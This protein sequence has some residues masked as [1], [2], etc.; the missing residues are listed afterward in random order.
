MIRVTT[1]RGAASGVAGYLGKANEV[2]RY[3]GGSEKVPEGL[4]AGQY[5]GGYS[6]GLH[7]KTVGA[8]FR[9]VLGGRDLNG[10]PLYTNGHEGR[11]LGFDMTF[12]PDKSFSI[13]WARS[14]KVDRQKIEFVLEQSVK[15][16]LEYVEKEVLKDCVRRGK[17]GLRRESAKEFTWAL[18][19]HGTSREQDPQ[20]HVHSVLCNLVQRQDGSY[21][22]IAEKSLYERQAEIRTY[23]DL[24]L[25]EKVQLQLGLKTER[26]K[27]GFRIEGI[28][29][30]TVEYFSKRR[31]QILLESNKAGVSTQDDGKTLALKTRARKSKSNEK[32]L[33]LAWQKEMDGH[34]FTEARMKQMVVK[35]ELETNKW[36]LESFRM[37]RKKENSLSPFEVKDLISSIENRITSE[38]IGVSESK[39]RSLC[40]AEAV[41]KIKTSELQDLMHR[42]LQ[43]SSLVVKEDSGKKV[44]TTQKAL[45]LL[46]KNREKA[47]LLLN[48]ENHKVDVSKVNAVLHK[49][50]NLGMSEEQLKAVQHVCMGGDLRLFVGAAGTGKSFS[51]RA[52]REVFESGGYQVLGLAPTGKASENL[53][54]SSGIK[55]KTIHKLL[56]DSERYWE[57]VR[58]LRD[59][60]PHHMT[61]SDRETFGKSVSE[62]QKKHSVFKNQ[63]IVID[64]ASMIGESLFGKVLDFARSMDS[65]IIFVGDD[66]QLQSVEKGT[67]FRDLMSRTETV[68]LTEVR[69]QKEGWQREASEA[70][71]NGEPAKAL[72]EYQERGFVTHGSHW[73]TVQAKLV[74]H[75]VRDRTK[76]ASKTQ[77]IIAGTNELVS[78]INEEVRTNLKRL[79]VLS[80]DHRIK[81]SMKEGE[82]KVLSL[83]KG[84]T[85]YFTKNSKKLG[86]QNG[87]LGTIESIEPTK[88]GFHNLSVLTQKGQMVS[89]STRD[90]N[91]I[92]HG[93]ACTVHKAQGDTVDRAYLVLDKSVSEEL[94]YVGMTRQREDLRLYM[95]TD[96]ISNISLSYKNEFNTKVHS[97]INIEETLSSLS[98][99]KSQKTQKSLITSKHTNLVYELMNVK[100]Q[101]EAKKIIC[102]LYVIPTGVSKSYERYNPQKLDFHDKCLELLNS[103]KLHREDLQDLS[104]MVLAHEK[105]FAP[106]LTPRESVLAY[107]T[108]DKIEVRKT[109]HELSNQVAVQQQMQKRSRGYEMGM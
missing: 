52:A 86:V 81:T 15:Q 7:N 1:L 54:E 58:I 73:K 20:L 63:I 90:Y 93:Y 101:T 26:T 71:R 74:D 41:G 89:F 97:K 48:S 39:L 53:Q 105:G 65:K 11:R 33:I 100:T 49:Y 79:G 50:T 46:Q 19:Q 70:I 67:P 14:N 4:E 108:P 35:S 102:A 51:L 18:F 109:H 40:A 6:L 85:I 34:G 83:S 96:L 78:S 107:E 64:E 42:V 95:S 22:A 5:F 45:E 37:R 57:E 16:T 9:N 47:D 62:L 25:A 103:D 43:S 60:Y 59:K 84:E 106:I 68:S 91:S 61:N 99:D 87:S 8:E 98:K 13:L 38:L 3:Y 69:R 31:A 80:K 76:D 55:S 32:D 72:L 66:K 28:P 21:G 82:E 27:D 94:L 10:N 104:R 56:C 36:T 24:A 23:F 44:F 17:G 92:A 77:I 30:A 29:K 2:E 88:D 75:W 12:S